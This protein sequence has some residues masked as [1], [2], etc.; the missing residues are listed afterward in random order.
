MSIVTINPAWVTVKLIDNQNLTQSQI[1]KLAHHIDA[2]EIEKHLQENLVIDINRISKNGLI[3]LV[4][5]PKSG[6]TYDELS[7]HLDMIMTYSLKNVNLEDCRWEIIDISFKSERP[8]KPSYVQE[9]N[10]HQAFKTV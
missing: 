8:G 1:F 2:Y 7:E 4:L 5:T 6:L 10:I 3:E 9:N